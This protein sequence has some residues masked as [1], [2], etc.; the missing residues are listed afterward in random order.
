M[1]ETKGEQAIPLVDVVY[2]FV[3][4]HIWP[5]VIFG[6]VTLVF[7]IGALKFLGRGGNSVTKPVVSYVTSAAF[8]ANL[9]SLLAAKEKELE[10]WSAA[11]LALKGETNALSAVSVARVRTLE[12]LKSANG[13]REAIRKFHAL[14]W[15][16]EGVIAGAEEELYRG[17][18]GLRFTKGQAYVP[19]PRPHESDKEGAFKR[20]VLAGWVV[21]NVL[22]A[23]VLAVCGKRQ[24]GAGKR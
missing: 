6:C 24:T 19:E 12:A 14:Q 3:L 22:F 20:K 21:L 7:A 5:L 16:Y 17:D 11:Y 8:V 23:G 4:H 2:G 13:I 9:D 18:D 15:R 10:T 1:S